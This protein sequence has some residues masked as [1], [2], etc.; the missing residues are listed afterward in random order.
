MT[1][2]S[3]FLKH[4]YTNYAPTPPEIEQ[5][6]DIITK[7][8]VVVDEI[9]AKLEDLD[10]LRKELEAT[11]RAHTDYISWHR[12]LATI[13][14]RLPPD[15]LYVVFTT[16][17]SLFPPHSSP[18]PAVTISHICRSWRSLALEMPLLWTQIS[19]STP[20]I[21]SQIQQWENVWVHGVRRS[22][23]QAVCFAERAGT[24]PLELSLKAYDPHAEVCELMAATGSVESFFDPIL[25]AIERCGEKKWSSIHLYLRLN[26]PRPLSLIFAYIPMTLPRDT[27]TLVLDI[28]CSY[29]APLSDESWAAVGGKLDI[30]K[31]GFTSLTAKMTPTDIG[32]IDATWTTLTNLAIGTPDKFTD[33]TGRHVLHVLSSTP[34]LVHLSVDVSA[35]AGFERGIPSQLVC[36]PRLKSLD[37]GGG[38]PRAGFSTALV[39]PSL[40]HLYAVRIKY[41][42]MEDETTSLILDLVKKYGKQL[43]EV[44]LH[45]QCFTQSTLLATLEHVPNVEVLQLTTHDRS[46]NIFAIGERHNGPNTRQPAILE[47]IITRFVPR[48]E[49]SPMAPAGSWLCPHLKELVCGVYELT[50]A[51]RDDILLLIQER[52]SIERKSGL[53]TGLNRLT[54]GFDKAFGVEEFGSELE[55]KGVDTR[56]VKFKVRA[57]IT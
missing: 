40:T 30:C 41:C 28:A 20:Q 22:C 55:R 53:L 5:L 33:F 21:T 15:I 35:R 9:N 24:C 51:I 48:I 13:V 42:S 37:I 52:R 47:P 17:L 26:Q 29:G 49:R 4:R 16:F 3:P 45:Y 44:A 36:L 27:P 50:D 8:Q 7:R 11:K 1:S 12:D 32:R 34:N 6:K 31:G 25:D 19:I 43:V 10:R 54:V 38:L 18:H 56:G 57:R 2:D 23:D 14:R 39:L 46:V